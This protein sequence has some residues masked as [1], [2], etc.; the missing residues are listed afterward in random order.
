MQYLCFLPCSLMPKESAEKTKTNVFCTSEI[1]GAC[2]DF[3]DFL[4]TYGDFGIKQK[5]IF[6]S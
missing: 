3:C 5:L 2:Y 6:F 1:K 4:K